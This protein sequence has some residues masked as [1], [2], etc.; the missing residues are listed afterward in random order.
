M[1][2]QNTACRTESDSIGELAVPADAYYG[3]HTLRAAENFP[4][5]GQRLR[6]EMI[7]N[8]ALIK[9]AAALANQAAGVLPSR[10]ADAIAA[11]CEELMDGKLSDQFLVDPIQ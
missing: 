11:A 1:S 7:Q 6:I 2:P 3:A 9:K 5:T 4:I 10:I 8:L